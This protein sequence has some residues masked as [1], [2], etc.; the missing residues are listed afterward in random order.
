MP[1]E[2]PSKEGDDSPLAIPNSVS[3]LADRVAGLGDDYIEAARAACAED[4]HGDAFDLALRVAQGRHA[5]DEANQ[6]ERLA[7]AKLID[8]KAREAAEAA[9][10]DDIAKDTPRSWV[11]VSHDVAL[12]MRNRP[13]PDIGHMADYGD[14]MPPYPLLYSGKINDVHGDSEA[15]KSWFALHIAVQEMNE[16]KRHVLYL[17]FEDDAG[18]VYQRLVDL[19]ASEDT[20]RRHFT[21]INPTNK[22]NTFERD[23][24]QQLI[25]MEVHRSLAVVDGV[26]E[27]M[28]LEGLT[29][30]DEGEVAQWHSIVTKPLAAA[31]W[32]VLTIDHTPHGENRAIGSQHK[33]SAITGVSYLLD[34][35]AQFAPGQNGMSRLK[36]EKDRPGWIRQN[37]E[38]ASKPQWY[39]DFSM[40][41]QFGLMRPNIWPWRKRDVT[42][43][44]FSSRPPED[45]MNSVLGFVKVSPGMGA[46]AIRE[47]VKGKGTSI[48]WAV[49][50]L[51]ERGCIRV[52][53]G[54]GRSLGHYFMAEIP[55]E[56][57]Q[58]L[59]TPERD[60]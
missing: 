59:E 29:G 45:I 53:K 27:A 6:V 20:I 51:I 55:P 44:Q 11:A 38:P 13:M 3:L 57:D 33:K 32:G 41:A 12:A 19:G 58:S 35:V 48:D 14:S 18:S 7:A 8:R 52:E 54:N 26:T 36:V 10:E 49:E 34:S 2:Q 46:R 28:A 16:S 42:T 56:S 50:W 5:R 47:A 30:R 31:G 60:T 4:G 15:G 24:Y 1:Y 25:T 21:Y 37:C 22:L 40:D 43:P 17:D 39:G 23:A 9:Y